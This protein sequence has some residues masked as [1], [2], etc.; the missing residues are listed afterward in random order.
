VDATD[1]ILTER[2]V[3][4]LSGA[5][6][7]RAETFAVIPSSLRGEFFV[8]SRADEADDVAEDLESN[9]T[10]ARRID[11]QPDGNAAD[12]QVKAATVTP[13]ATAPGA[14]VTMNDSVKNAGET[15][16]GP[17]NV[18]YFWSTNPGLDAGDTPL[19]QRAVAGLQPQAN[20]AAQNNIGLPNV[21]P[22]AYYVIVY[23][24]VDNDVIENL[25][26]NN[27][28]AVPVWLGPDL[29]VSS[30]SAPAQIQAGA[31][32]IVRHETRNG[33]GQG[34]PASETHFYWSS[35]KS[36]TGAVP[37]GVAQI[38][39]LSSGEAEQENVSVTAP[40]SPGTYYLIAVADG[41]SRIAESK[42]KNN[43]R[44]RAVTV[45]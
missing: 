41:P 22:G 38:G 36:L 11:V 34:S 1:V 31:A 43:K 18:A 3:L 15:P 8:L 28:R 13:A 16:A 12:L 32:A 35:N 21:A 7:N 6:S 9:N 37:A 27:T 2:P 24:D 33:G 10:A 29:Q 17:F 25:E 5:A 20:T 30:L 40:G 23:A 39:R 45:N 42:E 26:A 19:H 14:A 4:P 44:V